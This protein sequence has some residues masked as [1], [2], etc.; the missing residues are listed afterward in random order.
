MTSAIPES[1]FVR[2]MAMVHRMFR[3]EFLLAPAVVRGVDGGDARRV[4]EVAAHV[5]IIT[6]TLHEHHTGEDRYAWPLLAQRAPEQL[7]DHLAMVTSQHRRVDEVQSGLDGQLANWC[8]RPGADTAEQLAVVLEQ[9]ASA[10]VEHMDYE[11]RHVVPL[12]QAHIG[13]EEWN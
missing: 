8:R 9:L 13:F 6:T 3:R 10:L 11:E 12:M 4:E 1:Y 5:R 7:A 2:E